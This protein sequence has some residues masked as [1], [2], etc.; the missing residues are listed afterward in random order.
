MRVFRGFDVEPVCVGRLSPPVKVPC[1][2]IHDS[3]PAIVNR[4]AESCGAIARP[5]ADAETVCPFGNV[6]PEPPTVKGAEIETFRIDQVDAFL[7]A[8]GQPTAHIGAAQSFEAQQVVA[9]DTVLW[10]FQFQ[11]NAMGHDWQVFGVEGLRKHDFPRWIEKRGRGVGRIASLVNL[12]LHVMFS[13]MVLKKNNVPSSAEFEHTLHARLY[14]SAISFRFLSRAE[15]QDAIQ[16]GR[17]RSELNGPWR[18]VDDLVSVRERPVCLA[19]PGLELLGL[20]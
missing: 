17:F 6:K 4:K 20:S 14:L 2:G 8:F 10:D 15:S 5:G 19:K 9:S 7:G 16:A 18:H 1:L 3:I 13:V 11:N 12:H